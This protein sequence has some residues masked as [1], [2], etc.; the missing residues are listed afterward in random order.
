MRKS[1][2]FDAY[3]ILNSYYE[4]IK[5]FSIVWKLGKNHIIV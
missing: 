4:F 1:A 3:V 2:I 5:K